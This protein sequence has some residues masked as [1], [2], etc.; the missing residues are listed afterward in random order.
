MPIRLQFVHSIVASAVHCG[1]KPWRRPMLT[2][3][4]KLI[5]VLTGND[6]IPDIPSEPSIFLVEGR[7]IAD[8]DGVVGVGVTVTPAVK[9]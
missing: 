2:V 8:A 3:S 6:P 7:P 1:V 9:P 4:G 5:V